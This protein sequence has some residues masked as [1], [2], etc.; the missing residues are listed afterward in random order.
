[1]EI[2]TGREI[3][4]PPVKLIKKVEPITP[5]KPVDNRL[6]KGLKEQSVYK[7]PG[8]GEKIDIKI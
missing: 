7:I 2:K 1:M 5:I 6:S 4:I 8:L 3:I